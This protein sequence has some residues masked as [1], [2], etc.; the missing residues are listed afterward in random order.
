MADGGGG[1]G[2]DLLYCLGGWYVSEKHPHEGQ[3]T[4]VE[5]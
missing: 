2:V 5:R 3:D 1:G 4:V